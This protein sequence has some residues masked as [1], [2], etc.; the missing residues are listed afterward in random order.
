MCLLS[1]KNKRQ[2]ILSQVCYQKG[3]EGSEYCSPRL[4]SDPG[5]E[6]VLHEEG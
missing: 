2:D 1:S 5:H 3:V 4:A 6:I